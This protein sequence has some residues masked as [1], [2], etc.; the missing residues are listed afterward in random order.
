VRNFNDD[1]NDVLFGQSTDLFQL[2]LYNM[3]SC[4]PCH[5]SSKQVS[6]S[7]EA[8]YKYVKFEES[9]NVLGEYHYT[10]GRTML[11]IFL[12]HQNRL[13]YSESSSSPDLIGI[14]LFVSIDYG[15]IFVDTTTLCLKRFFYPQF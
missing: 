4:G 10:S 9:H 5:I 13:V 11:W 8:Y 6:D 12:L 3:A 7:I 14:L 2:Y 1:L 15:G